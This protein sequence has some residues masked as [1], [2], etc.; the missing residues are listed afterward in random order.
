M[1]DGRGLHTPNRNR[2]KME[3]RRRRGNY[4][5]PT[6]DPPYSGRKRRM[7]ASGPISQLERLCCG[8]DTFTGDKLINIDLKLDIDGILP[9]IPSPMTS[10]SGKK[11]GEQLV[12][13][14]T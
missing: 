5:Q 4:L 8:R 7:E 3:R 10:H 1:K 14:S 6:I 12:R 2:M 9:S 11:I 13:K